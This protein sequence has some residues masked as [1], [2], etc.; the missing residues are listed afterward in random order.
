MRVKPR[1]TVSTMKE[2]SSVPWTVR[3][4]DGIL[5]DGLQLQ[6]QLQRGE[7]PPPLGSTAFIL[8]KQSPRRLN[9]SSAS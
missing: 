1:R 2:H 6:L 8:Q 7:D 5:L 4:G 9:E 3:S